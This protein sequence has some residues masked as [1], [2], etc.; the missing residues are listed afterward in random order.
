MESFI[1]SV[2]VCVFFL[3]IALSVGLR[4][5]KSRHNFSIFCFKVNFSKLKEAEKIKQ[6]ECSINYLSRESIAV[7]KN[8]SNNNRSKLFCHFQN[9]IF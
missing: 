5:S 8:E 4:A 6:K 1:A 7:G 3:S 9:F 2:F